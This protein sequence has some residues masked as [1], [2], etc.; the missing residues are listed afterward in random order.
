MGLFA[1]YLLL[2]H[3]PP[4]YC[5]ARRFDFDLLLLSMMQVNT[6][7]CPNWQ[8]F[9]PCRLCSCDS[10]LLQKRRYLT[11][12]ANDAHYHCGE[13]YRDLSVLNDFHDLDHDFQ[14]LQLLQWFPLNLLY[15]HLY[16]TSYYR[17]L[18]LG[19]YLFAIRFANYFSYYQLIR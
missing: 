10:S 9:F 11:L 15:H 14:L 18:S 8:V 1:L 13:S 19:E 3:L 12:N 2:F 6:N 5:L 17:D 7:D 4:F 16:F